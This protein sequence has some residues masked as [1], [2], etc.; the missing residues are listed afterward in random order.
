MPTG[1]DPQRDERQ[2]AVMQAHPSPTSPELL[3]HRDLARRMINTHAPDRG[4]TGV[5]TPTGHLLG[6]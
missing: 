3:G 5:Q 4:P 2:G 6:G 1:G